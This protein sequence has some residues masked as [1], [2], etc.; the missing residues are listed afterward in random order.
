MEFNELETRT[1]AEICETK[2]KKVQ[3]ES[4]I[5]L[6]NTIFYVSP[7]ETR[8]Y[9]KD[10]G[11]FILRDTYKRGAIYIM[12]NNISEYIE[13][14]RIEGIATLESYTRTGMKPI[15]IGMLSIK[16]WQPRLEKKWRELLENAPPLV[17]SRERVRMN[18]P[19]RVALEIKEWT[20]FRQEKMAILTLVVQ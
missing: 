6:D 5:Q 16:G 12:K 9:G 17:Q 19:R 15:E 3:H 13:D 7:E 8:N 4:E 20:M 10:L 14:L 18:E 11:I 2:E 1:K